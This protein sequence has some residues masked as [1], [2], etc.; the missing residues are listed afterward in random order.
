MHRLGLHGGSKFQFLVH[1][2]EANLFFALQRSKALRRR[3]NVPCQGHG[4]TCLAA[5]RFDSSSVDLTPCAD[6]LGCCKQPDI[7]YRRTHTEHV[8]PQPLI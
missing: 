8:L 3:S 1:E 6:N 4:S 7:D 2:P 5:R